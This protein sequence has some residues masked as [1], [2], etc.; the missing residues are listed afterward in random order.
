MNGCHPHRNASLTQVSSPEYTV[1]FHI[2]KTK[3]SALPMD[4]FIIGVIQ[5]TV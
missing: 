4:K 1:N 2:M 5:E 3:C